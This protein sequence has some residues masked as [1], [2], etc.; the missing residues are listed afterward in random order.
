MTNLLSCLRS[1]NYPGRYGLRGEVAKTL[2]H[3]GNGPVGPGRQVGL[4]KSSISRILSGAQEPKLR[5]A[6]DL[7]K[8]LGVTLD[9]LVEE[10]PDP[11]P[12]SQLVMVTEDELTV[13]KIVRRLGVDVA[14]DRLLGI[15]PAATPRGSRAGDEAA[16][17]RRRRAGRGA[18]MP[19]GPTPRRGPRPRAR[20]GIV[21]TPPGLSDSR[22][23]GAP[24]YRGPGWPGG[25]GGDRAGAGSRPDDR[26]RGADEALRRDDGAGR[27]DARGPPGRGL[28]PA[29]PERVGQD[30][31]DPAP[32]RPAAADR[33][34]GDRWP[35]TT[36]GGR[37]WR[38][39]GWSRTCPASCG[40]SAR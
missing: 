12:A 36:A 17:G 7:A 32:A 29:G 38:S 26:D 31:H 24:A 16:R 3:P 25:A 40:C 39:G 6:Y 11:R 30:D 5:L 1:S 35:G 28:R 15:E 18:R 14:I 8:A 9:Y 21:L 22:Q 4:S 27:P 34:A 23:P 2:S 33:G 10:S 20:A 19:I 13:L 37:A